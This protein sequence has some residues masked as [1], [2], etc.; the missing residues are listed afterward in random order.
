MPTAFH[1]STSF[2]K[3]GVKIVYLILRVILNTNTVTQITQECSE[4]PRVI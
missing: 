4:D 1:M 3:Q 2:L